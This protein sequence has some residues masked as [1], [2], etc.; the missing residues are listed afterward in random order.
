MW[1]KASRDPAN[2][3]GKLK[4]SIKPP[5]AL[6]LPLANLESEIR[7][8]LTHGSAHLFRRPIRELRAHFEIHRH[9]RQRVACQHV[10]DLFC[11]LQE[12]PPSRGSLVQQRCG[13]DGVAVSPQEAGLF[14]CRPKNPA[15]WK[16]AE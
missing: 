7:R 5:A 1:I 11:D 4:S 6:L 16:K 8:A 10:D 2:S 14:R 12:T 13:I 9:F 15:I 3:F